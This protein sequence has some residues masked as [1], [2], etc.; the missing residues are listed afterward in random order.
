VQDAFNGRVPEKA[1]EKA[2]EEQIAFY[3]QQAAS[4]NTFTPLAAPSTAG[5]PPFSGAAQ[6]TSSSLEKDGTYHWN[7]A[8]EDENGL[9]GSAW[10]LTAQP[11]GNSQVFAQNFEAMM[12]K[13]FVPALSSAGSPS[14]QTAAKA[15]RRALRSTQPAHSGSAPTPCCRSKPQPLLTL[16]LR[17]S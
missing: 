5:L 14:A 6:S 10:Q 3:L 7:A 1:G 15:P 9:A 12:A 8:Q 11:G 16:L 13:E 2:M 4:A 17:N